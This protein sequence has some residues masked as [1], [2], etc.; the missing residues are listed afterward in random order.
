MT[1]LPLIKRLGYGILHNTSY[2]K[3][4]DVGDPEQILP[5]VTLIDEGLTRLYSRFVLRERHLILEMQ[6][7]VTFYHFNKL[8]TVQNGDTIR[9]P[10]PYIM[11]LPNDPFD[12]DLVK[13]LSVYDSTGL[14]RPLGDENNMKSVFMVQYDVLHNPYPKDLE[15]L[16]VVYQAKHKPLMVFDPVDG[17]VEFEDEIILPPVL[18]PA[19]DNYVAYMVHM[20]IGTAESITKA[21]GYMA[22]YNQICEDVEKNDLVNSSRSITNARF[23]QNGWA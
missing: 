5:L 14:E 11:D 1:L 19:L 15:V 12:E 20:R 13:V 6:V 9:V 18:E 7:G 3:I 10:Y 2:A 21:Q 22:V 4:E 23:D 17:T 8:Y 16:T